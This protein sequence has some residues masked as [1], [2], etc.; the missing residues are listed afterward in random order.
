MTPQL[1]SGMLK[2]LHAVLVAAVFDGHLALVESTPGN[3]FNIDGTLFYQ[4]G[5]LE[6]RAKKHRFP[7]IGATQEKAFSRSVDE[8]HKLITLAFYPSRNPWSHKIYRKMKSIYISSS[9]LLSSSNQWIGLA[10]L[11][12]CGCC[13]S[14]LQK[15][16][17]ST[18]VS[19]LESLISVLQAI[20][21]WLNR[22]F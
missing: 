14:H 13:I 18:F 19:L 8:Q 12:F 16:L 3:S 17:H 5:F 7:G 20:R 22:P 21:I 4:V 11:L 9:E 1:F 15:Q 2:H 6:H 10:I